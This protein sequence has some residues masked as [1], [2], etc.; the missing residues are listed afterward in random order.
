MYLKMSD[1]FSGMG[2]DFTIEAMEMSEKSN[3]NNGDV[4]FHM[5][6]PAGHFYV[7][8]KG[9]VRLSLGQT[10]PQ[11]YKIINLESPR[12]RYTVGRFSQRIAAPAKKFLPSC[13]FE[14]ILARNFH[15]E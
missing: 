3:Q 12:F 8:V 4:I 11:V 7:L 5:G 14:A 6:D 9:S 15:I 1:F 13:W 10:G 2:K